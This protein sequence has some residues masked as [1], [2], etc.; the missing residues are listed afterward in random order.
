MERRSQA[1]AGLHMDFAPNDLSFIVNPAG[2]NTA[3]APNTITVNWRFLCY[4]FTQGRW[5]TQLN[6]TIHDVRQVRF[7]GTGG[8]LNQHPIGSKPVGRW[9]PNAG[10]TSAGSW[11]STYASG[12][13]SGDELILFET[14]V[15][16]VGPCQG[17]ATFEAVNGVR[18]GGLVEI[19]GIVRGPITSNHNSVFY[20]T[21]A[22][23]TRTKATS[24]FY[25]QLT[26]SPFIVTAASLVFGGLN[27]INFNWRPPH[28]THG[29]GTD[30]DMD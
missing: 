29:I 8:H 17:P 12:V 13:A 20:A 15:A 26:G 24:S 1:P 5:V 22:V 18:F 28:Q 9:T 23:A 14:T 25:R 10:V 16:D 27:D 2:P 11:Q 7:E 6:V 3:A 21:P 30:V 4:D 19:D